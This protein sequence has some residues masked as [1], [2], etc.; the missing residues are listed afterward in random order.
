MSSNSPAVWTYAARAI[1]VAVSARVRLLL[2]DNLLISY[3]RVVQYTNTRTGRGLDKPCKKQ[4][5]NHLIIRHVRL[6]LHQ[7]VYKAFTIL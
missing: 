2:V 5:T 7:A 6:W 1:S 3:C 4:K